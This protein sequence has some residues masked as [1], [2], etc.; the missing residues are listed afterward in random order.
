MHDSAMRIPVVFGVLLISYPLLVYFGLNHVG[1][2]AVALLL[3]CLAVGRI[4]YSRRRRVSPVD[5]LLGL[6]GMALAGSSLLRDSPGE[7]L[8][9]PVYVN[10]TMLAV[11]AAS[12]IWPPTVVERLARIRN[13]NLPPA[14]VVYTR[15][16]TKV[17]CVFFMLNGSISLYTALWTSMETWVLYNGL[18]SYLLIG[19]L[20]GGERLIRRRVM[21]GMAR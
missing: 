7:L 13:P 6:G 11:F 12:V 21:R 14:G 2:P 18:V 1:L 8:Y 4:L 3:I 20:F 19:A 9:Y 5:L 15:S 16:V 10:L 17:W